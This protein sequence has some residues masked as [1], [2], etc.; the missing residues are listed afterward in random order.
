MKNQLT[1]PSRMVRMLRAITCF[2]VFLFFFLLVAHVLADDA[3]E[4]LKC[5]Q[6]QPSDTYDEDESAATKDRYGMPRK[7][8][9]LE[10]F[11]R[12]T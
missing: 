9:L 3:G 5:I 8:V 2:C 12:T 1:I 10:L 4:E 6:G 11:G 7:Q